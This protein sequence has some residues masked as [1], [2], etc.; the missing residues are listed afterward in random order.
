MFPHPQILAAAVP[1]VG[2]PGEGRARPSRPGAR[3]DLS[4]DVRAAGARA[5]DAVAGGAVHPGR[6]EESALPRG[7]TWATP[8][9]PQVELG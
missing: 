5:S 3:G 7:A 6:G 9:W 4:S 2:L 1:Q 8:A